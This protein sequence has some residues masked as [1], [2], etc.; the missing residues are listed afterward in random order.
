MSN[1]IEVN[2]YSD[3]EAYVAE[4]ATSLPAFSKPGRR[5]TLI[6]VAFLLGTV[7][8]VSIG[9]HYASPAST[10]PPVFQELEAMKA[11]ADRY[12]RLEAKS[13]ITQYTTESSQYTLEECAG[14]C[15]AINCKVFSRPSTAAATQP[16]KCWT[17]VQGET[18]GNCNEYVYQRKAPA[19]AP[20]TTQAPIQSATGA[21]TCPSGSVNIADEMTCLKAGAA[22][23]LTP[24]GATVVAWSTSQGGCITANGGFGLNTVQGSTHSG[25]ALVCKAR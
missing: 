4:D 16:S 3:S 9:Y 19:T 10:V 22:L 23:G 21:S 12:V 2:A 20:S 6:A 13:C 24:W 11:A 25:F 8:V 1:F 7:G 18:N 17:T 14:R 15:G 5:V